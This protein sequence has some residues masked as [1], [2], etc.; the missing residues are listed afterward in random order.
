MKRLKRL[1][2]KGIYK[3]SIII[4][5]FILFSHF[6]NKYGLTEIRNNITSLGI[7]G[8]LIIFSLRSI[9]IIFPAIPSTAYSILSGGLFGFT[10]GYLIICLADITS[11][12]FCFSLSRCYGDK[13]LNKITSYDLSKKIKSLSSKF[14]ENNMLFMM[15]TLMTGMFD[16]ICYAIGLT[17]TNP[18]K[19]AM[20]LI[21][22]VLLSNAPIV[23]LG[24]GLLNNGRIILLLSVLGLFVLSIINS[25]LSITKSFKL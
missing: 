4:I 1:K 15:A 24:A 8:P 5:L 14:L 16:F 7:F 10:K 6:L 22:S 20:A 11:C 9:S 17:N 21:L 23:A 19:F 25:N 12:F 13:I 2:F 18:S 3:L